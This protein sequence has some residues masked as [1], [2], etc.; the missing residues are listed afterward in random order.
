MGFFSWNCKGCGASI[1]APYN[2]PKAI[3]W[4][5]DAVCVL[6]FGSIIV[7]P[8]DGYGRVKGMEINDSDN[9]AWWHK[10][11]WDEAGNPDFTSASQY[12][13]DQG[14]FYEHEGD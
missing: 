1:K 2:L 11:C 4:H 14:Y 8:Y 5:N 6:E 3:A 7:G 13:Q 9:A 12:A 10:K